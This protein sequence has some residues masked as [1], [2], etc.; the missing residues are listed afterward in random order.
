MKAAVQNAV[1]GALLAAATFMPQMG[2]AQEGTFT[3]KVPAS[4]QDKL[5]ETSPAELFSLKVPDAKKLAEIPPRILEAASKIG[6]DPADIKLESGVWVACKGDQC[7]LIDKAL[8]GEGTKRQE[9]LVLRGLRQGD[10]L[11][12]TGHSLITSHTLEAPDYG[13]PGL[14]KFSRQSDGSVSFE[15]SR[16]FKGTVEYKG[17]ESRVVRGSAP[18]MAEQEKPQKAEA[19]KPQ[20]Q[21]TAG[22][23]L[24]KTHSAEYLQ[25]IKA[26]L[27]NRNTTVVLVVSVPHLCPPCR[28]FKGDVATAANG[29]KKGDKVQFATIDFTSFEDARAVMGPITAFPATFVFPARPGQK[30]GKEMAQEQAAAALPFIPNAGRPYQERFGR[31][32]SGPLRDFIKG[33]VGTM[34]QVLKGVLQGP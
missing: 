32:E 5:L 3:E 12:I 22:A 14:G 31:M 33:T 20:P 8:P 15:A 18:A 9:K 25:E 29:Y 13:I 2:R 21:T 11:T 30:E 34:G 17:S 1:K 19:Q 4:A 16:D 6:V 26:I 24:H 28:D 7:T 27:A 10:M 23:P